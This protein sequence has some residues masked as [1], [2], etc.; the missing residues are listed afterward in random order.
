[1]NALLVQPAHSFLIPLLFI[2][3]KEVFADCHLV[4]LSSCRR[5]EL[6]PV[7]A[8]LYRYSFYC[9]DLSAPPDDFLLM[10]VII[11]HFP[12]VIPRTVVGGQFPFC[13]LWKKGISKISDIL[14]FPNQVVVCCETLFLRIIIFF[15]FLSVHLLGR[16]G[17]F[18]LKGLLIYSLCMDFIPY[19]LH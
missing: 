4:K 1:M 9:M 11:D 15:I 8:L 2:L 19:L 3:N 14:K 5:K 16:R 7:C 18:I 12:V 6:V 13:L 10:L 17:N